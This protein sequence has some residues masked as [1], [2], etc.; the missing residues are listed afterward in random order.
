MF[1]IVTVPVP[2]FVI[3]TVCCVDNV[4]IAT[5]PNDSDDGV[6]LTEIVSTPVPLSV[7]LCTLLDESVTFRVSVR[8]PATVGA[9]ATPTVQLADGFKV[10]GHVLVPEGMTKFVPVAKAIPL[11]TTAEV[12]VLLTVTVWVAVCVPTFVFANDN[13]GGVTV[14]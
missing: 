8:L 5:F 14:R 3:V 2:V 10:P 11:M 4:L 13:D 7:T 6:T 9:N 1:E 12:L